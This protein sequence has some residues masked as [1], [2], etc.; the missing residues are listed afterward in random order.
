M[1][2]KYFK[3]CYKNVFFPK[4]KKGILY[5]IKLITTLLSLPGSSHTSPSCRRTQSVGSAKDI[6]SRGGAS[7]DPANP[8]GGKEASSSM[9][10][11]LLQNLENITRWVHLYGAGIPFL[12]V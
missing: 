3:I 2:R 9:I 11:K 10:S 1:L 5:T 12:L 4:T 8:R 7:S 6:S